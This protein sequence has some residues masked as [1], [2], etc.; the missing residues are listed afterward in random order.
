MKIR[1]RAV[2]WPGEFSSDSSGESLDLTEVVRCRKSAL[3]SLALAL[4]TV[5]LFVYILLL[6]LIKGERPNVRPR[7]A[8]IGSVSI[9]VR[10]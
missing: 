3:L 4:L 5:S 8:T 6:P 10:V 9:V 2:G 7:L 1:L